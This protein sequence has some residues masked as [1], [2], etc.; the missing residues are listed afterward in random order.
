MTFE[1]LKGKWVK[2]IRSRGRMWKMKWS[3][4]KLNRSKEE[5][6]FIYKCKQ[7]YRAI[8]NLMQ[9]IITNWT[10]YNSKTRFLTCFSKQ[11]VCFVIIDYWFCHLMFWTSSQHHNLTFKSH[12]TNWKTR[13]GNTRCI[14][15]YTMRS[16]SV[17]CSEIMR[18]LLIGM[19][20]ARQEDFFLD[21]E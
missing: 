1:H 18:D 13:G 7:K 11:M 4:Y 8:L 9:W 5:N 14:Q 19:K 2:L 21:E 16:A 17:V 20:I 12:E 10:D 6:F 15:C 3:V